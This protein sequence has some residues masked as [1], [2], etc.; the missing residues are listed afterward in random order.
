MRD[1]LCVMSEGRGVR[2]WRPGA[3]H[4][5]LPGFLLTEAGAGG[6]VWGSGC[7]GWPMSIGMG[8]DGLRV[9]QVRGGAAGHR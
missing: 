1:A 4:R 5:R 2:G 8:K 3:G 7:G 9:R 6:Y